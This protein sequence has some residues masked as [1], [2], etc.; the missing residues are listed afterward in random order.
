MLVAERVNRSEIVAKGEKKWK[1]EREVDA[2]NGVSEARGVKRRSSFRCLID[3]EG[4][5]EMK[6][7]R[8]IKM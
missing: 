7:S 5:R 4:W 1:N 8:K 2:V 6:I 3:Q